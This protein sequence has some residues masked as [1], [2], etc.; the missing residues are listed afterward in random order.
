MNKLCDF[1]TLIS[2]LSQGELLGNRQEFI[3]DFE[4]YV[5]EFFSLIDFYCFETLY[6]KFICSGKS[7][8]VGPDV[9]NRTKFS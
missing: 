2:F 5:I 3:R 8:K 1:H 7:K 9:L 6:F 4:K